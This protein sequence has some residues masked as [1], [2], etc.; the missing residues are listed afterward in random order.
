M[1]KKFEKIVFIDIEFIF[2]DSW[3][4]FHFPT[5]VVEAKLVSMRI[6]QQFTCPKVAQQLALDVIVLP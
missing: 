5:S 3:N 6:L 2:Q 1:V 4:E